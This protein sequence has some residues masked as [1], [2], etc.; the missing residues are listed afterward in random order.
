[1]Y[2]KILEFWANERE[3]DE[4][5]KPPPNFMNDVQRYL[6]G[7]E[8]SE[9]GLP[10][11]LREVEAQRIK[12]MLEKVMS[13]RKEKICKKVVEGGLTEGMLFDEETRLFRPPRRDSAEEV[14]KKILVRL[15]GD[16][17]SFVGTDLRTYGPY[18]AEDVVLLPAQN[19][20]ALIK[21]GLAMAIERKV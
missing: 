19:A 16:V 7:L 11:R 2:K 10:H 1:M 5:Q 20:D 18:K 6:E 12:W 17:P 15:L 8:K 9:D 13:L 14:A 4:L 3:S 21:R